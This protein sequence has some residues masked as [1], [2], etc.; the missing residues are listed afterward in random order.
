MSSL[1]VEPSVLHRKSYPGIGDLVVLKNSLE[2]LVFYLE[3]AGQLH[4][5]KVSSAVDFNR[6]PIVNLHQVF[7]Q[8][9]PVVRSSEGGY[10]LDFRLKLCGGMD[11]EVDGDVPIGEF[12]RRHPGI[13]DHRLGA[14]VEFNLLALLEEG[15]TLSVSVTTKEYRFPGE[16]E[17]RLSRII[18]IKP[19]GTFVRFIIAIKRYLLGVSFT[20]RIY[21]GSVIRDYVLGRPQTP[22]EKARAETELEAAYNDRRGLVVIL[23]QDGKRLDFKM[24]ANRGGLCVIM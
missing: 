15:M 1:T 9:F 24:E 18:I 7:Q 12:L 20:D 5:I 19:F 22:D 4:P 10:E 17:A 6:I 2:E 11:D 14:L 8:M 13:P 3:R 23:S 21:D 16:A